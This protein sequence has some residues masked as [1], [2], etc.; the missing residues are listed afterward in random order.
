[1][2]VSAGL[3]SPGKPM[4]RAMAISD[5][6]LD[7]PYVMVSSGAVSLSIASPKL[8]WNTSHDPCPPSLAMAETPPPDRSGEATLPLSTAEQPSVNTPDAPAAPDAPHIP[9]A[10]TV[11]RIAVQGSE[12]RKLFTVDETCAQ[13]EILSNIVADSNH[14]Y[15]T[16]NSGLVRLSVEANPG[17]PTQLV[18]NQV[19][20]YTELAIDGNY[21][22]A[23]RVLG[24]GP[25]TSQIWRINKAT[26]AA[27][28]LQ[29]RNNIYAARIASSYSYSI[30][31]GERYYVYWLEGNNLL[32]YEPATSSLTT[33]ATGVTGYYAEGG[34]MVFAGGFPI[35][36][37]L[38]FVAQNAQVRT[39]NNYSNTLNPPVYTASGANKVFGI[40]TDKDYMLMLEEYFVPCSPQ[41]CIGGTYTHYVT[42]AARNGSNPGTLYSSTASGIGG[43]IQSIGAA[44]DYVFWLEGGKIKRLPKNASALPLTN[45]KITGMMITQGIQRPD[46]SV[47][48]I[49]GRRTFVRV[50]VQSDGPAVPGVTARLERLDS[51]NNVIETVLPVNSVGTNL[52][53]RPSPVR[54]NL[55]DSFLFELP[56]SWLSSGLRLRARLNPYHAP[57]ESNY[58]DNNWSLGPLTFNTSA[59]LKVQFV[60]W[61]YVLNNQLWYPRFLQDIIQTYSWLIRA[62]PLASKIIFDGATGNQPG[63]HPNLW[64]VGD[65]TLGSLVDQ[66]NQSCQD[67][68][69]KNPNGTV[70]EDNRSLCASRYTNNQMGAMRKDNGLP[71]NRFFYGMIT[72]AAGFF[73]RGQAC[74][75]P[76]VSTGPVGSGTWGWDND[77]SYADWYAAHEIGHTL[78]RG[79]PDYKVTNEVATNNGCGLYDGNTTNGG[80]TSYPWQLARIGQTDDTEGLDTGDP[81]L[82]IP[83]A[84]YQGT[85]WRD[86][87]SYCVNQWISDYTYKG[88]Y[89]YM[90]A[91][92]SLNAMADAPDAEAFTAQVSGDFLDIQGM[93]IADSNTATIQRLRRVSSAIVPPLVPGPYAIRLFDAGNAQLASYAFTPEASDEIPSLLSFDQVVNFVAGTRQVRIVRLN[94]G[95]VLTTANVS[96]NA[97]VVSNVALQGAPN[98]VTGTVT[99]SWSASDADGDPLTFDILYSGN[100]GASYQTVKTSVSGANTTIDTVTLGGGTG[101]LRVIASDGANTGRADS[102]PFTMA[103]KLPMP[104]IFVPQNNLR[105]H[106][107][108][109]INFSGAAMDWQDGGVTGANLVWSS[110]LDGPLGTGELISSQTLKVGTHTITLK[111]TNSKGLMATTS[112]TVIVDDDLNLL[113]PMLTAAPTQISFSFAKGATASKTGT[114][115]IGNAGSGDLNWTASANAPWLTLGASSG[116][117]PASLTLTAN[118]TGIPDGSALSATLTLV[119]PATSSQPTQ[120]LTIP[121]TLGKGVAMYVG[122]GGGPAQRKV[123]VPVVAR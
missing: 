78:G 72:D 118:P 97:P 84:V 71:Q 13:Y 40:V 67:L 103:N 85:V 87:M 60:A 47:I 108:Q 7:T 89:D 52:T 3:G 34:R 122:T 33:I 88:I 11:N 93:I 104:M 69:I 102:A 32:R 66:T 77:G 55:N 109:L 115:F 12:V 42:R 30:A 56:W 31:N 90:K 94:D 120:T 63:L 50:F 83:R 74:C 98:P 38:V 28:L 80:D 9:D 19:G 123:Y 107:G 20:G 68:L 58:G 6:P 61:G 119:A 36:T 117:A 57:P 53:V 5:A 113:D 65:N 96:P 51:S 101:I 25:Y 21:V 95:Q 35:F 23:L 54:T 121:V 4:K 79:H 16:N 17:D 10:E 92:P 26:G 22:V 1:M 114:V 41:P 49:A 64:F 15:W 59:A 39:Y 14:V 110:N 24:S 82:G 45:M 111:A 116:T 44:S 81:S 100:N 106:Y 37:D 48:L 46:N 99:L 105:I 62:Y 43:P 70:K 27:T 91:N 73:P 2:I 112:I 29:T 18:T 86:V 8:F 75:Q 76:N